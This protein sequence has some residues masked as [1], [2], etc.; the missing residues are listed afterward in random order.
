M[1]HLYKWSLIVGERIRHLRKQRDSVRKNWSSVQD[2][3]FS[4]I[5]QIERGEKSLSM[6]KIAYDLN[7]F[8]IQEQTGFFKRL[9]FI[10]TAFENNTKTT[11]E[12]HRR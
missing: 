9:I 7:N 3:P 12:S 4:Y 10:A 8:S 6:E 5:A 2:L 1:S 11:E